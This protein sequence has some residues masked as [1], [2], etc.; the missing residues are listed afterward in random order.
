MEYLLTRIKTMMQF[1]FLSIFFNALTGYVLVMGNRQEEAGLGF[2]INNETFRLVLGILTMATGLLKLL[3]AVQGDIPVVGDLLP[4]LVGLAAGSILIF[5]FYRE[6]SSVKSEAIEKI[7]GFLTKNEKIIGFAA[8][9]A[10][11]LHF[12][13]PSVLLL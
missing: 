2:S 13:F 9:G 6:R 5:G 11:V 12:M 4:A 1:Y 8:L 10:A 7:E 3:S